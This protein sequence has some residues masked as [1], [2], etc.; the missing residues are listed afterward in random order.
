L[1]HTV[2]LP[3]VKAQF[4]LLSSLQTVITT[5]TDRTNRFFAIHPGSGAVQKC[6]PTSRFATVIR[7]LWEQNHPVLL[8]AGPADTE[9]VDDLLQQLSLPPGPEM[10]K[11]L[12]H[13]LLL[14]VAQHLQECRC[15]LGN[16]S[17]I[18]HLAAMLGVPTVAIFGP[19]DPAMWQ[20][21]GPFVKVLQGHTLEDVTVDATVECLNL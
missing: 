1:A 11:M 20:P 4:N 15:Y 18:T 8:L 9:R 21:V 6:W 17:G 5:S 2:G 13:A 7:R 14:E 10:F 19:T 12:T 3:E 16:D